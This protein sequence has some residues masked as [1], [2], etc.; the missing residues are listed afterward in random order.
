MDRKSR[1]FVFKGN[2]ESDSRKIE[3]KNGIFISSNLSHISFLKGRG[4]RGEKNGKK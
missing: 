3:G 2:D 1:F 4:K